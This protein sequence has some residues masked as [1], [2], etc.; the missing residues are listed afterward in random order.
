MSGGSYSSPVRDRAISLYTLVSIDPEHLQ[1]PLLARQLGEMLSGASWLSTQERAFSLLALGKLAVAGNPGNLTATVNVSDG[2]TSRFSGED[3][4][5]TTDG[6]DATVAT[7]GS[8]NLYA[9][10]EV[11]GIPASGPPPDTDRVLQVRRRLLSRDGDPVNPA[12]IAQHD[13]LVVEISLRTTDNTSIENVVVTDLLPACFEV[14]NTRLTEDRRPVWIKESTAP[15]YIDVRDDRVNLFTTAGGS[16][17]R[18]YYLVRATGR[19]TFV[20]GPVSAE[21]MYN[22]Q[23]YSTSG[24]STIKVR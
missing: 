21:A 8:G 5:L 16:V 3:L 22:G 10:Y 13:L 6:R 19:G 14:E 11:S 23:Y 15:D 1:V 17:S 12:G 4:I 9:Y 7:T 18:F 2:K 24:A 20:H